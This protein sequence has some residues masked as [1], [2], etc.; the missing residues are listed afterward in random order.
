[1]RAPVTE[2]RAR[3]RY[4]NRN[5]SADP[6][7]ATRLTAHDALTARPRRAAPDGTRTL[8]S[9]PRTPLTCH[10]TTLR[11][12]RQHSAQ[13]DASAHSPAATRSEHMRCIRAAPP[14]LST[15]SLAPSQLCSAALPRRAV[16]TCSFACPLAQVVRSGA[17]LS[18]D[19]CGMTA[20]LQS[21]CPWGRRDRQCLKAKPRSI[22]FNSCRPRSASISLPALRL[23]MQDSNARG[24]LSVSRAL[25]NVRECSS[26]R[27][28]G[29]SVGCRGGSAEVAP[30]RWG[31][32]ADP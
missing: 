31:T 12:A 16:C 23:P 6:N 7:N 1:M 32:S 27:T 3:V 14:L 25:D 13:Y 26:L 19:G 30:I 15:L 17:G 10:T 22:P 29:G 2:T 20:P 5:A 11:S 24:A 21:G 18:E 9:P 8:R 4:S 28:Y